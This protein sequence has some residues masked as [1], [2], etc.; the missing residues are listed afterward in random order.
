MRWCCML[1]F[2]SVMNGVSQGQNNKNLYPASVIDSLEKVLKNQSNDTNKAGDFNGLGN[3]YFQLGDYPIALECYFK[4]LTIAKETGSKKSMAAALG[5]LGNIYCKQGNYPQALEYYFKA[6]STAQEIGNKK[7][8]ASHLSNIGIVY[9]EQGNYPQALEYNFKSL[10][11]AR[12][13]GDKYIISHSLDNLGVIYDKQGDYSKALE[14]EF[15]ALAIAM[16]IGKKDNLIDI[17]AT[18]GDQGNYPKALEYYSKA[19]SGAREGGDKDGIANLYSSIGGIYTKQKNYV[20][21]KNFLDSAL[22]ISKNLG[23]KISIKNTYRALAILDSAMGKYKTSYE[24]YEKYIVY[25]DSL[26]NQ[27]SVKKITQMEISYR[28]EKREDSIILEEEKTDIIKTAEIN[29]K[30]IITYSAIVISV[31]TLLLA[32]LL[33]NRQQI[34]RRQDKILFEKEKQRMENDLT[35]A[36]TMLDEYIKSMV[37]KNNLL[38][39]FKSDFEEVKK[40]KAKEESDEK[41]IEQLE[42]LNKATILTEDDWNR[43]KELFEQVYKGFFIRLKEKLPNLTQA[44]IRLI[45]LTKL[46]INTKNMAAIIG[47][48]NTTIEQTR[49]RLRKKLNLTKEDN[50]SDIIE[51]V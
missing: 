29:R 7:S 26:I 4:A 46:K 44:E 14:Y 10:G 35:N 2:L 6:L 34:K 15:K 48:S 43:F 51:S 11:I 30:S 22:I 13:V 33:I 19:L 16:E 23:D 24:D 20:K 9:E 28:F 1:L 45:C 21:A 25:R 3:R 8:M 50:L 36:K 27:E 17:G 38:E 18:Y 40:L 37:E 41:R 49:Y 5:N 31:L 42:H 12:E 39:Q 32:I 47:V